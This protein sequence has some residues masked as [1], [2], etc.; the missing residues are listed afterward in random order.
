[1]DHDIR[2]VYQ[3]EPAEDADASAVI[4]LVYNKAVECY[5]QREAE[6]PVMAGLYKYSTAAQ[7]R[8]RVD[9]PRTRRE[10]R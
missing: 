4:D 5:E 10:S 1:M 8:P 6:Y 2:I 9:R 7:G 3:M